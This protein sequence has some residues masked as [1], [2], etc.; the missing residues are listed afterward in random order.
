MNL[1]ENNELWDKLDKG[2]KNIHKVP[3]GYFED[4]P[5]IIQAK[6]IGSAKVKQRASFVY[7]L[8][9]AVPVVVLAV[10]A[11]VVLFNRGDQ[12]IN[13]DPLAGISTEALIDYL[14]ETDITTDEILAEVDFSNIELDF[15]SDELDIIEDTEITEDELDNLLD[16]FTAPAEFL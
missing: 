2:K 9:Y 6:A 5:Q 7:A 1:E 3:E 8:R 15:N 4:L 14:A 13:D 16:D 11:F 12:V 10:I